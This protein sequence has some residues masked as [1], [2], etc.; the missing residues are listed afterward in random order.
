MKKTLLVGVFALLLSAGVAYADSSV[1][2]P[3]TFSLKVGEKVTITNYQNMQIELL[4][5]SSSVGDCVPSMTPCPLGNPVNPSSGNR[6]VQ[7]NISTAGGCGPNADPRCLG[8]PAY[9]QTFTISEGGSVNALAL[10]VKVANITDTSATF[11][12][13]VA[14]ADDSDGDDDTSGGPTPTPTPGPGIIPVGRDFGRGTINYVDKIIICPNGEEGENCSICA[15]GNCVPDKPV[16]GGG[17]SA[18]SPGAK[19]GGFNNPPVLELKADES[20]VS[21]VKV[22]STD[23]APATYE[24]KAKRK[25]RLLFLFPVTPE[26][27]YSISATGTTTVSG[28]PWWNFLAW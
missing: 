27:T 9:S 12:V 4:K 19:V 3:S 13:S 16:S 20:F 11:S 23:D 24:V 10:K 6:S 7:V 15:N 2:Y 26:I 17:G 21:A 8:A 1:N 5:V 14:E 25:A 18:T 28:R 22:E